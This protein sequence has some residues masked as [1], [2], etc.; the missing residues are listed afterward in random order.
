MRYLGKN[1][2]R[3][4]M[5]LNVPMKSLVFFF[6]NNFEFSNEGYGKTSF[7]NI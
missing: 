4:G 7:G 2:V 5:T 6:C 3:A 1:C